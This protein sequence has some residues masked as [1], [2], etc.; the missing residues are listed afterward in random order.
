MSLSRYA[1][2]S[3]GMPVIGSRAMVRRTSSGVT[4]KCSATSST[5]T[6]PRSSRYGTTDSM[7]RV[8][9]APRRVRRRS[10]TIGSFLARIGR[11]MLG[12]DLHQAPMHGGPE[13]RRL[14]HEHLGAVPGEFV[15]QD[16]EVGE[17]QHDAGAV[18]LDGCGPAAETHR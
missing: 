4:S 13:R 18:V 12:G 10:A 3:P 15:G 11:G 8:R 17:V 6:A 16:V 2:D 14:V 5:E 7:N 9:S 1:F